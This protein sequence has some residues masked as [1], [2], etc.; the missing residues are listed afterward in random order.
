MVDGSLRVLRVLR[1][2]WY[3]WN[4]AESNIKHNKSINLLNIFTVFCVVLLCVWVP[5]CGVHCGF[6]IN[7]M[8]SSSYYRHFVNDLRH[9][10]GVLRILWFLHQWNWPPRYNWNI[11][12]I[13]VK[14]HNPNPFLVTPL[15]RFLSRSFCDEICNHDLG[16]LL[17]YIKIFLFIA[18]LNLFFLL[19]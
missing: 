19:F 12:V 3:S 5:C 2:P 9:F 8:F 4:I 18:K 1:P 11:V 6:R 10:S 17:S 14:H 16:F 15:Y 7:T 13:G